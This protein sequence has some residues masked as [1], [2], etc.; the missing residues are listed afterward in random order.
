MRLW[1]IML[2]LGHSFVEPLLASNSS[3]TSPARVVT[4]SSPSATTTHPGLGDFVALGLGLTTSTGTSTIEHLTTQGL[5]SLSHNNGT[6]TADQTNVTSP[7]RNATLS[8]GTSKN[9]RL[10]LD[11]CWNS[12]TSYW[13][14]LPTFAIQT[15]WE[16]DLLYTDTI[17]TFS[18]ARTETVTQRPVT[19]HTSTVTD[20]FTEVI[21]NNGFASSTYLRE[22]VYTFTET[23]SIEASTYTTASSWTI[24][25]ESSPYSTIW[26]TYPL[27]NAPNCS[28]PTTI[29]SQCEEA[30]TSWVSLQLTRSVVDGTRTSYKTA[31]FDAAPSCTQASIGGDYCQALKDSFISS[32]LPLNQFSKILPASITT[33]TDGA[34]VVHWSGG[35]YSYGT[36]TWAWP[37]S[38][39]FFAPS[40]TL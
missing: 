27:P 18:S 32:S 24:T 40:C 38:T 25:Y 12:W 19:P 28:L 1:L 3:Y 10:G 36:E 6:L 23:Q 7:S 13:S 15:S 17:Y 11:Q 21:D 9:A 29:L 33:G 26:S 16:A 39:A 8:G 30:W 14:R 22:D 35:Y 2:L 31:G 5:A 4:T 34:T 37:P 20:T